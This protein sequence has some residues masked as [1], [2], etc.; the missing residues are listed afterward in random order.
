MFQASPVI[1]AIEGNLTVLQG[2]NLTLTCLLAY[3]TPQPS[4]TWYKDDVM[5]LPTPDA[6]V[7]LPDWNALRV[8][9]VT[10]G[11]G[12]TYECRAVNAGGQSSLSVQ[13]FVVGELRFS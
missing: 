7:S 8:E 5:V 12:G 2:S 9:F 13:V 10:Q 1:A 3:G 6:R 4:V 11:D